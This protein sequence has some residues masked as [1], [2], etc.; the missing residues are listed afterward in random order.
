MAISK[1]MLQSL[2]FLEKFVS[3]IMLFVS[4]VSYTILVNGK[5]TRLFPAAKGLRQGDPSHLSCL[6]CV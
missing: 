2:G 4:T 1:V 3:W 5:P 6:L